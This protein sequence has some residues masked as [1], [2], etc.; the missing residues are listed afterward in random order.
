MINNGRVKE[1]LIDASAEA[2]PICFDDF[3][4]RNPIYNMKCCNQKIHLSCLEMWIKHNSNNTRCLYCIQSM[5]ET[6]E[7]VIKFLHQKYH[8][9]INKVERERGGLW[10]ILFFNLIG[11]L[12]CGAVLWFVYND[13]K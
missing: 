9:N 6:N 10:H 5:N 7:P 3:D 13:P 12:G 8:S 2:C 1:V 11:F 4:D